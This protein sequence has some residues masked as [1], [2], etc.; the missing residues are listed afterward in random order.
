VHLHGQAVVHTEDADE[1]V[2]RTELKELGDELRQ[3]IR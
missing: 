2:Y 1:L 3:Y